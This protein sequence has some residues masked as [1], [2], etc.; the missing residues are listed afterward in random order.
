MLS[1]INAC[2]CFLI[3]FGASALYLFS[4]SPRVAT[5]FW[6]RAIS[7]QHVHYWSF[8]KKVLLFY[9]TNVPLVFCSERLQNQGKCHSNITQFRGFQ[10]ATPNIH[11]PWSVNSVKVY[12]YMCNTL[13]STKPPTHKSLIAEHETAFP[14]TSDII[15]WQTR[16]LFKCDPVDTFLLVSFPN[17]IFVSFAGALLLITWNDIRCACIGYDCL[18]TMW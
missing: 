3:P 7:N 4:M 15:G 14:S 17:S 18:H 13:A 10:T 6:A 11:W 5:H 1:Y 8:A 12:W 16:R 9:C 2:S